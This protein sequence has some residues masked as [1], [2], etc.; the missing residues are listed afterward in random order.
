LLVVRVLNPTEKAIDGIRLNMTPRGLKTQPHRVGL[1]FNHGGILD[2]VELLLAPA[3]RIADVF[4]KTDPES[5]EIEV[6]TA[7]L[8]TDDRPLHASLAIT[9]AP[10]R[11]GSTICRVRRDLTLS[12]GESTAHSVL[13]VED[14]HRWELHD[15]YLYRVTVSLETKEHPHSRDET[16]IKTGFREF[17]FKDG[18]FRLNGKRVFLRCSH[19][20]NH[21]P[22]GLRIPHDQDL[23][24]R[25]LIN[26]K[27]MGFNAIRFIAGMPM[28]YQLDLA[29]ELGLMVY[30]ECQAAWMTMEVT[31]HFTKWYDDAIREMILRDRNHPSV[32]IW[33][34]LN[35]C[36]SDAVN[37]H[38]AKTL[39]LVR[40]FD[41]TRMVFF[42]SGRW[43]LRQSGSISI[44]PPEIACRSRTSCLEPFVARNISDRKIRIVG[45]LW[46]P[47]R[48]ATHPGPNGEYGVIRWIAPRNAECTVS[49]TFEDITEQK[50]TT[51][52]HVLHNGKSLFSAGINVR[53]G[54]DRGEYQGTVSVKKGESLDFA[55]GQGN[56][57]YGGDTTALD[58]IINTDFAEF[59]AVTEFAEKD[60]PG[61]PWRYGML[62]AG[63][64]PR[65]ETFKAFEH[66]RELTHECG[67]LCNPG[68]TTWENTLDDHHPYQRVPHTADIIEFLRSVGEKPYNIV[69][70]RG[71]GR[72]YF[73]SEYGIGSA[74]N[75]PR[76]LRLFEQHGNPDTPDRHFYQAQYDAF[77]RD[78]DRWKMEKI[79]GRP[80][81]FFRASIARMAGQRTLGINAIRS[82]PST[83]GYSLTGTV[84]QV[85]GGEGLWTT[86]RELKPGTTEALSDGLAPLR[87]CTFVEPVNIYSGDEVTLDVV[88]ANEDV[89][90]PGNYP[91]KAWV[92]GPDETKVLERH[93][94]IVI[95][96]GEQP[97][98][99]PAFQERVKIDG[100][101]GKYRLVVAFEKGAAA[102]GGETEFHVFNRRD[103][104][105]VTTEVVFWGED[106]EL[107]L[108]LRQN[109]IRVAEFDP[110]VPVE[111]KR[112][113]LVAGRP[114]AG[115]VVGGF[116]DLTKRIESGSHVVFLTEKVFRK[117]DDLTGYL[118][119]ERRGHIGNPQEWLYHVDQ[120]ARHHAVFKGLQ[121]GGLMDYS[122]YREILPT[123]FFIDM[124]TPD[125]AIAGGINASLKY[126]SGLMTAIYTRGRGRF[127]INTL[128]IRENLGQVPQAERL[129]RNMLN[130]M[131]VEK[132]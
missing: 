73:P 90:K 6:E 40:S 51:D 79:F 117:S 131:A 49:A 2:S 97:F 100:P 87:W 92:F 63:V 128:L 10:H 116:A 64:E 20:C 35:E 15:P 44:F 115:G 7:L 94:E 25:D 42:N 85:M 29:D 89:L 24:R 31:P 19:T 124:Q 21:A 66:A 75:W 102:A 3:A 96:S 122:Y 113:L 127:L 52:V 30:E 27:T 48:L 13:H 93:F 41:D 17:V 125:D 88:L 37:R 82:N 54:G 34:L 58:V 4:A 121:A 123:S 59:N 8:N 78:F 22:I 38:A 47:G 11:S 109:G 129:L 39:D 1:G 84:D 65:S 81:A 23:F 5:G 112:L 110:S 50:T 130:A 55:V 16:S 107:D 99:R 71:G 53:G 120:W 60:E 9:V 62:A 14:P 91:A 70:S 132:N 95:E 72:P 45:I 36:A 68:S 114:P 83:V 80:E 76:V 67:T 43:D 86:F 118:P 104:P 56:G 98:A 77:L 103:M 32:V 33:G 46:E 74:V 69:N 106:A 28:R 108:W 126:E 57:N 18:Y 61:N 119:L 105:P 111:T 12:C 26:A 101:T